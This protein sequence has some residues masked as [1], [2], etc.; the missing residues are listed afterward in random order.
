M[1]PTGGPLGRPVWRIGHIGKILVIRVNAAGDL[2]GASPHLVVHMGTD[3]QWDVEV[4]PPNTP[5]QAR[6]LGGHA[7]NQRRLGGMDV[8]QERGRGCVQWPAIGRV[9]TVDAIRYI[10]MNGLR[11]QRFQGPEIFPAP[12]GHHIGR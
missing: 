10:Q 8:A 11:S 3:S 5:P 9:N 4:M 12:R 1:W 2:G 7:S 6:Q